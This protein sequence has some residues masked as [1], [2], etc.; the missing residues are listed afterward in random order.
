VIATD[1]RVSAMPM[2][3]D[4]IR[5]AARDIHCFE[6]ARL[7][8]S[9][10]PASEPGSHIDLHL[11]NGT[12]RQYSLLEADPA[13]RR[14]RVC[15][16]RA[17]QS[18]G[19]SAYIFDNLRVGD[20]LS[21]SAPRNNFPLAANA[22][23]SLLIAGGIG[24]TPIWSMLRY[25]Q[26]RNMSW[27]LHYCC[28]SRTEMPFMEALESFS[29]VQ[30]YF[31]DERSGEPISLTDII[32]GAAPGTHVY[33]CGPTPMLDAYEHATQSLPEEMVHLERFNLQVA[34]SSQSNFTVEL[35]RSGGRFVV[36]EGKSILQVLREHGVNVTSSCEQGV[37]GA[38][39]TA[40]ISGSPDHKDAVLTARE[41]EAGKSMMICCSGSKTD[42]LVLDL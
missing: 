21:I 28:R 25:L 5:F 18:R 29:Q 32:A 3:V 39:E 12:V 41:R 26:A 7:D 22:A 36:P 1:H 16:K 14:Y 37:C 17:P 31:D 38:C 42:C 8:G 34:S 35:A 13:P 30:L 20:L 6:L 10:L 19:G 27:E 2:R 24:I 15:I 33:C 11:P 40:V 9:V 23:H 4:A